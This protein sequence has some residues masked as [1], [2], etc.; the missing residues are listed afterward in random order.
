MFTTVGFLESVDPA[1]AFNALTALADQHISVRGDDVLVPTLA[2]IVA[3]AAMA[4]SAVAPLVRLV[5]PSLRRRTNLYVAPLNTAAA[6]AVEPGSPQA[7]VDLRRQPVA[8]V[9]GEALNAEV[10]S[11]PVAVQI[12]SCFVW[13]ADGPIA[14]V[15][16]PIF[17]IRATSATA[18][19]GS[20]WS[21]VAVTFQEDLP[22]GRYQVVGFRAESAGML[23]ARLVFVGGGPRPG[24][25]GCDLVS[26]IQ[27][28]IFRYGELGVFGEFEDTEQPTVDCCSI[29]ADATQEFYFDLIQLREGPG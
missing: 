27:D 9:V 2:Q 18:L 19:V 15:S 13:L 12:Q 1:G 20:V 26:D 23:A 17:T 28:Y 7:V 8:L 4:E 3:V 6:A 5:S 22:R 25:L 14:P 29:S 11:N 10:N 16:G 21:N 24:V